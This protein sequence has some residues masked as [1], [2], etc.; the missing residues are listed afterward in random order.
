MR[1]SLIKTIVLV[2]AALSL[3]PSFAHALEAYPRLAIWSPELWRDATVFNAQFALF[4]V[5]GAPIDVLAVVAAA[6]L[7]FML[8]GERPRFGFALGGMLAFAL[9]LVLWFAV[10]NT[11]NG[12]LATWTLGPI[13]PDFETVRRQWEFGHLA[14][15]GAKLIAFVLVALACVSPGS[16]QARA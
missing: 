10:V 15:A 12:V 11:A 8:R 3:A 13:A 7:A 16:A 2:I 4:A 1:A 9:G 5:V 14:V 6:T